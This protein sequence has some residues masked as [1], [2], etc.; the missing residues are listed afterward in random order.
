MFKEKK[1]T[2]ENM[3]FIAIMSAIV[4]VISIV[5]SFIPMAGA[6]FGLIV[7]VIGTLVALF[8]KPRFS[9]VFIV[10]S[11]L[12]ALVG[13]IYAIENALFFIIPPVITGLIFGFSIRKG[14]GASVAILFSA[15]VQATLNIGIYYLIEFIYKVNIIQSL[16]T[17]TNL[18]DKPDINLI[19][20]LA[21]LVFSLIQFVLSYFLIY[22]FAENFTKRE[23]NRKQT[24][25]VHIS[26]SIA[27]PVLMVVSIFIVQ[28]ISYVL[29]GIA[30][31]SAC[32]LLFDQI[33]S[34][35]FVRVGIVS[36]VLIMASI[37]FILMVPEKQLYPFTLLVF[38]AVPFSLGLTECYKL[39]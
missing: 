34:R 3:T 32:F 18:V 11:V 21:V 17:L 9:I 31:F 28:I 14:M 19:I 8:A 6:I 13:S 35:K 15:I 20:G 37:A 22:P 24:L 2:V 25:S 29:L 27:A 39:N 30:V 38:A 33:I 4:V 36:A 5:T 7:P 23:T 16:L 10:L 12:L 1:T 26:I